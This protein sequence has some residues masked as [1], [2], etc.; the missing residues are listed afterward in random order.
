MTLVLQD[1]RNA[2]PDPMLWFLVYSGG[3]LL[4]SVVILGLFVHAYF[5]RELTWREGPDGTPVEIPE[6]FD[7][8]WPAIVGVIL[9]WPFLA[10][11]ALYRGYKSFLW[12]V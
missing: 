6:P 7:V 5:N 9:G 3:L 11:Y 8:N 12:R 1:E 10:L 4:H 2:Y